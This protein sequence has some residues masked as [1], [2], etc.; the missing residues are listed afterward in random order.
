[1]FPEAEK[2]APGSMTHNMEQHQAFHEGL[3]ALDAFAKG[4]QNNPSTYDGERLR[5]ILERL[6]TPF[7]QHLHEE[8]PT[9][10]RSKLK[11]IFTDEDFRRIWGA[12]LNWVIKTNPKLT[13]LP[14]VLDSCTVQAED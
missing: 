7:I 6:G 8:I 5:G 14:W 11:A 4:V 12:L 3:D 2:R 10:E 13:G 9:L 1:M